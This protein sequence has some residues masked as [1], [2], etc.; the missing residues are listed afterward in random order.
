MS[1]ASVLA[2]ANSAPSSRNY[3]SEISA[4]LSRSDENRRAAAEID[5][6]IAIS[7]AEARMSHAAE[8]AMQRGA[9]AAERTRAKISE[10]QDRFKTG[11]LADGVNL[12]AEMVETENERPAPAITNK[13]AMGMAHRKHLQEQDR[14]ANPKP[15]TS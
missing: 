4:L 14:M 5:T 8:Q 6:G 12:D 7:A 1:S 15:L 11:L 13:Y 9:D 2:A 3:A 10:Q